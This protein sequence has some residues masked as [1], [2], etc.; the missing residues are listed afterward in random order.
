MATLQEVD[1]AVVH[2]PGV[3]DPMGL[4]NPVPEVPMEG[5][6]AILATVRAA[7]PRPEGEPTQDEGLTR[8]GD[9]GQAMPTQEA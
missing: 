6:A 2:L 9:V 1:P 8:E 5:E 3:V 7:R 4:L